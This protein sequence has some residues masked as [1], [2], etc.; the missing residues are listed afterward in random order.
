MG[1][2]KIKFVGDSKLKCCFLPDFF[3]MKRRQELNEWTRHFSFRV[4]L[5]ASVSDSFCC[6][7]LG[8]L[9]CPDP[10]NMGT[11]SGE[12]IVVSGVAFG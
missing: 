9:L 7:S 11:L 1:S 6:L 8:D 10:S 4:M 12:P 2:E 5:L 3:M